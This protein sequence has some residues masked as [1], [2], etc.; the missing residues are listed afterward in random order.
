VV[1]FT[2]P[3]LA[4]PAPPPQRPRICI[5]GRAECQTIFLLE[6]SLGARRAFITPAS[7]STEVSADAEIGLLVNR[8]SRH[9]VGAS[10]GLRTFR[11]E[12]PGLFVARGRYRYWL[13]SR[14]GL[15]VS[16]GVMAGS[17][18]GGTAQIGIELAD[19]VALVIDVN[20]LALEPESPH[21]GGLLI[22]GGI[23]IRFGGYASVPGGLLGILTVLL[24]ARPE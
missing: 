5:I 1:A 10:F 9:G 12:G 20:A 11:S 4:Q 24:I 2:P 21:D 15:D 8:W 7:A 16:A 6:Y 13:A 19:Q 3:S 14:L 23:A 17:A 18:T 22:D